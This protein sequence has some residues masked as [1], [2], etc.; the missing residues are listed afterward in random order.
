MSIFALFKR[1]LSFEILP[2]LHNRRKMLRFPRKLCAAK[3]QCSNVVEI[4]DA[5]NISVS[6]RR[7]IFPFDSNRFG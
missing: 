3:A 5:K 4:G 2:M 6:G 7:A 1:K